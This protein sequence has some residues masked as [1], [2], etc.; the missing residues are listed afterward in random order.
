MEYRY[1]A[2]VLKK[3][4]V[5]ETDRIY[6]FFTREA[7]KVSSIAKGVRKSEAKLAS[8]LETGSQVDIIVVKTRGMGKIAGATLE[9]SFPATHQHFEA[10]RLILDTLKIFDRLVEPEERDEALYVF[11]ESYLQLIEVLVQTGR[12]EKLLLVTEAFFFKLAFQLGYTLELSVS[13]CSGADLIPSDRYILSPSQG[14]I[15][16][17]S[18]AGNLSD[19]LMVRTDT[20][21]LLRLFHQHSLTQLTKLV[22]NT[23]TLDEL[24]RF[25]L[26]F[27]AW[28]RR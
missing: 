16:N 15:L 5:G 28:I 23:A 8:A 10:L 7:G 6:T 22:V 18:E 20:I 14:G 2:I 25:R 12:I 19:G 13:A 24:I 17:V 3:R 11:L 21:K 4:E 1:T 26:I 9:T 27:L